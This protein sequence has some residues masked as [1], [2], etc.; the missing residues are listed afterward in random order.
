MAGLLIVL[1]SSPSPL[2][3]E[4]PALKTLRN[5]GLFHANRSTAAAWDWGEQRRSVSQTLV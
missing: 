1:A 4:F 2:T 3:S 5:S